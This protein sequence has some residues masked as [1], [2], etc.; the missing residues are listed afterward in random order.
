MSGKPT[1]MVGLIVTS[2]NAIG[3]P[4]AGRGDAP[5]PATTAIVAER[6]PLIERL[7]VAGRAAEAIS[8]MEGLAKEMRLTTAGD[9]PLF[10]DALTLARRVL[11][12]NIAEVGRA[13]ELEAS[14]RAALDRCAAWD[15]EL[16]PQIAAIV[17]A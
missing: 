4:V 2:P 11:Y 15:D 12:E 9:A 16:R 14:A 5:A 7:L 1:E 10:R 17:K 6:W 8:S 13:A 3:L